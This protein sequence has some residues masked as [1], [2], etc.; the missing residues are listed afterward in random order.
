MIEPLKFIETVID[1]RRDVK[2]IL[3]QLESIE[4]AE[5]LEAPPGEL[6]DRH[7]LGARRDVA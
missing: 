2:S 4:L 6:A 5:A 7:V 3:R 1:L